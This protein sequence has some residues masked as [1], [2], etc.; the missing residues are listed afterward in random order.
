MAITK[1][2]SGVRTLGAGEVT[3]TNILDGTIANADVD[4]SADIA[5]SK[6]ATTG[7]ASGS[8]FL[9]GDGAWAAAGGDNSPAYE[10]ARHS[11]QSISDDVMTKVDVNVEIFDTDS[12]YDP[13]TNYRF[14][15]PSGEG[16]KYFVY[17]NII[18]HSSH[19]SS[20]IVNLEMNVK[21][22]GSTAFVSE[23]KPNSSYGGQTITVGASAI[24]ILSAADYLELYGLFNN[25][26]GST[27]TNIKHATIGAYKLIGI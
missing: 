24:L 4:A 16:G 8:T 21:K 14:T 19:S 22:N 27:Y 11:D 26:Q 10:A 15:V 20:D 6:L 12:A 5:L 17:A 1:V 7:T 3:T 2:T 13:T 25:V 18:F 9:R 23:F